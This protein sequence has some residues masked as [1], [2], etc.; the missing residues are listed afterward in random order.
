M[1]IEYKIIIIHDGQEHIV[2]IEPD[3]S[4]EDFT[5]IAYSITNVEPELQRYYKLYKDYPTNQ[6]SPLKSFFIKNNQKIILYKVDH[7]EGNNNFNIQ[8]MQQYGNIV[9]TITS[10]LQR[11]LSY[12]DA[13]LQSLALDLIPLDIKKESNQKDKL[14]KLLDWYKNH[15]FSWVNAPECSVETCS[16]PNTKGVGRGTPTQDDLYNGASTIEVY[17]CDSNHTTRF[18]RYNRTEKLLYTR[19]GRCGEWVNVFTLFLV[20]LGFQTRYVYDFT[21]HV[22]NEVYLDNRWQHTDCCEASLDTPLVYEG[23]WNKK[24]NYIFAFEMDG[25]YDVTKRYSIKFN[26]LFRNM[27]PE[28][29]LSHYIAKVNQDIRAN[30]LVEHLVAL[31]KREEGERKEFLTF[32]SRTYDSNLSGRVSG[33]A[34][35]RSDRGEI[36]D[37]PLSPA[38]VINKTL[39]E[40]SPSTINQVRMVGSCGLAG[41][42]IQLTPDR[43]DQVGAFWLSEPIDILSEGGFVCTFKFRINKDGADGMAFVLQN[44]SLNA[45]GIGGCGLGYQGIKNSIAIE[46]DTYR[47]SDHCRDPNDNHISIQSRG[48][49]ENSAHHRFSLA[50]GNPSRKLNDGQEHECYITYSLEK[51][52]ISVW[53][54]SQY[55][56]Q[57]HSIDIPNLIALKDSRLAYIGMTAATGG[58]KQSHTITKFIIGK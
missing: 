43:T 25:V 54:D 42:T 53:V 52:Q 50:L 39:L 58:L 10:T 37:R 41:H 30:L 24:L 11:M 8:N 38:P 49:E 5:F 40:I 21:D 32:G 34:A 55:V 45:L 15:F 29:M 23:G 6:N 20:A 4:Y 35:W 1:Q 7:N 13:R 12:N 31:L 27:I 57:N 46:F 48:R 26:Q 18:P 9:R 36:G 44:D 2:D 3:M 19:G 14:L 56:I 51:K 16:T 17:M 33:S 47:S 22:W 28:Y